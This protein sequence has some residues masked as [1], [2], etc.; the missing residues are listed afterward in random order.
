MHLKI[1]FDFS[2]AL[3]RLI[4]SF[5]SLGLINSRLVYFIGVGEH[6]ENRYG[7]DRLH[8]VGQSLLGGDRQIMQSIKILWVGS[9]LMHLT[10]LV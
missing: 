7:C 5:S 2:P 8:D 3:T 9:D 4:F 10:E 6:G 1:E